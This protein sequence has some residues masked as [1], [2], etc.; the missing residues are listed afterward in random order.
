MGS[1]RH[2]RREIYYSGRVQG[3]GFRYTTQQV[4][5][6]FD[7]TGF[8]KNLS[9]GRVYLVAEA[10]PAELRRFLSE[11]DRRLGRY[12]SDRKIAELAASGEFSNFS[13]RH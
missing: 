6:D 12:I 9:D 10:E 1:T 8:V 11:I 4:A 13:I 3:V 5:S 7:L 2:Q